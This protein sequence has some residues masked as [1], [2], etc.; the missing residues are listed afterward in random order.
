MKRFSWVLT[1]PI[2]LAILLLAVNNRQDVTLEIW[3]FGLQF[4]YPLYLIILISVGLGILT[5]AVIAWLSSAATRRR[6]KVAEW[7]VLDLQRDLSF[8]RE[9]LKKLKEKEASNSLA[10]KEAS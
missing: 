10:V 2:T 1:A 6:A 3:P 4:D 7:K 8:E 5:G 9:E